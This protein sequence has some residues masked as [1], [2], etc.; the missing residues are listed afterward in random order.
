MKI[1]QSV[2]P[3]SPGL[4]ADVPQLSLCLSASLPSAY[5]SSESGITVQRQLKPLGREFLSQNGLSS[6]EDF[7]VQ[8]GMRRPCPF[9]I[10]ARYCQYE[11]A[12]PREKPPYRSRHGTPSVYPYFQCGRFSPVTDAFSSGSKLTAAARTGVRSGGFSSRSRK[13]KKRRRP[14]LSGAAFF[15]SVDR[16]AGAFFPA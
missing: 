16:G 7:P 12:L 13:D 15:A 10:M 4:P 1:H 3:Q 8:A 14:R 2:I 5:Q 9:S 6:G 11:R